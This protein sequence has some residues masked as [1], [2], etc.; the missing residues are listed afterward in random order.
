MN[1][2]EKSPVPKHLACG[3]P[4]VV[5]RRKDVGIGD[6][7]AGNELII[8]CGSCERELDQAELDPP[9]AVCYANV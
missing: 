9:G 8:Y 4:V 3:N 5:K 2:E 7:G 6:L 1:D